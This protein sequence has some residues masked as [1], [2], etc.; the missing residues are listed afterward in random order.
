LYAEA[1]REG[2][3]LFPEIICIENVL[4]MKKF[5]RVMETWLNLPGYYTTH[6]ELDG[7]DFTLQRKERVILILHRQEYAFRPIEHY[8]LPRL[9]TRLQD[10]LDA[11]EQVDAWTRKANAYYEER[12]KADGE[13]SY[14]DRA[15]IYQPEQKDPIP[16]FS[17]Y[18]RDRSTYRVYDQDAPLGHRAFSRKEVARLHTFPEDY[19]FRGGYNSVYKQLINSVMP[20]MA[21]AIGCAVMDYF[22]AIPSLAEQPKHRGYRQV[23]SLS[24]YRFAEQ[25]LQAVE[26]EPLPLD[27]QEQLS[28]WSDAV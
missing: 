15:Y 16:L 6:F 20:S 3:L 11:P 9:G 19:T 18:R 2:V 8:L 17:N 28:L 25:E 26:R 7:L 14:R 13:R 5:R 10:Y 1:L 23:I 27:G 22:R 4:G 24:D 21:Y 12:A